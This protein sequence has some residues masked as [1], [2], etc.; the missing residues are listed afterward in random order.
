MLKRIAELTHFLVKRP[1]DNLALVQSQYGMFSITRNGEP[2]AGCRWSV[3]QFVMAIRH[4]REL[5]AAGSRPPLPT[6]P[7]AS[8]ALAVAPSAVEASDSK[9]GATPPGAAVT[10]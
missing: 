5:T 7:T 8:L 6:D 4:F 3:R 9:V 10:P 1:D 2:I